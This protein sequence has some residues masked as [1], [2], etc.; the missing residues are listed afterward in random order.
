M[1]P[2]CVVYITVIIVVVHA[3]FHIVTD[4]IRAVF[5]IIADLIHNSVAAFVI[6]SIRCIIRA[7]CIAG[8]VCIPGIIRCSCGTVI[9]RFSATLLF[10]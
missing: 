9:P 7:I 3:V 6:I 10:T 8:T 4:L 5:Y 2:I 1:L